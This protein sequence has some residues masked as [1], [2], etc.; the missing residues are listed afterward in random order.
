VENKDLMAVDF[1]R[2]RQRLRRLRAQPALRALLTQ[3]RVS[4][5]DLVFPLFIK[6]GIDNPAPIPSMPGQYQWPLAQIGEEAK[7]VVDLGIPAVLLFGVP[8]QK[9]ATGSSS[10]CSDSLIAQAIKAIKA[11]APRLLVITDLCFCEYTDH[12]HCGVLK[13][14]SHGVD[15]DNDTTLALLAEQA[16]VHARAGADVIAPS[17]MMDGAIAALRSVL[18][19]AGFNELALMSYAVKYASSFYGPF[20]DAAEGTPAF[21]DRKTHQMNPANTAEALREAALD[22]EEG[23]DMLMVKPAGAYLDI[24]YQVKQQFPWIPCAAYQV[25]GEYAMIQAAGERGWLDS[26]AAMCE[27]LL[28]IKRSGADFIITY[29]AKHFAVMAEKQ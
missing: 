13:E 27:S 10:L 24:I 16:L 11:A 26:Q 5:S 3:E 18:D 6:E 15:V 20:R 8:V 28:A 17:G 23:A 7:R 29:F 1:P 4:V 22:V 9:D 25:S 19:K 21:G 2:P 12:G 14:T